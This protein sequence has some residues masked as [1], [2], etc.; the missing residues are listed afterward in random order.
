[1]SIIV[2][3]LV[4]GVL[5][6]F[7]EFGHFIVAKKNGIVVNEFAIGMGPKLF[8]IKRGGTEYTLR[9]LPIGGACMMLGEDDGEDAPGSFNSKSVW[10]RM[11]VVFA[12]PFFNFIM[13]YFCA[14]L[15]IGMNGYTSP[16]VTKVLDG[17]PAAQS[18]LQAGDLITEADGV[19]IHNFEDFRYHI[20]L[21]QGKSTDITYVRDGE[22]YQTVITPQKDENGY[23]IIG[24]QGG[25]L[26]KPGFPGIL[27]NSF[28]E[29]KTN[30]DLVIKSLE[31]L[32]MGQVSRND[33]SGP[34]G[35]FSAIGSSYNEAAKYGARTVVLTIANLILLLSANLGV[36]NLLPL[37]A[38]DGGRLVFLI[39]EAVRRK[40]VPREKEGMV[41]FAG[42]V[43]LMCFMVF[44]CFNDVSRLLGQ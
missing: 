18:T 25:V 30:I 4:F 39:V 9:L 6:M 29:V 40:P 35:M 7:H 12:G 38:L 41:H 14:V 34:V 16:V 36:M 8:G 13:A 27:A 15:I 28:Y 3:F 32:A 22:D 23:Y 44:V 17:Y 19:A 10:A 43:L 24:I 26:V 5:V 1:M 31:M 20:M 42:F 2:A 37:P 11:A 21:N 33:I